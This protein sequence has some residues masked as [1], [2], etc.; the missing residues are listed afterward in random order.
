[1]EVEPRR[2]LPVPVRVDL[3][4]PDGTTV[5]EYAVNVSPRGLCLHLKH[6]LSEGDRLRVEFTLP[7]SGPTVCAEGTVVWT[8]WEEGASGKE[9]D[10]YETGVLLS[11]VEKEVAQQ[12]SEYASQPIDRRR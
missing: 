4:R 7:P 3:Q 9:G 5:V 8:S 1:M 12:L 10:F 2:D 6:P 11:G